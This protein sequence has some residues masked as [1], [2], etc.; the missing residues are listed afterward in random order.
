MLP[1][2]SVNKGCRS[3]Q[4]ITSQPPWRW[5]LRGLEIEIRCLPSSHQPQQ[6]TPRRFRMGKHRI[7]APKNWG[8]YQRSDFS[9]SGLL[10]FPTHRKAVNSLRCLFF[11]FQLKKIFFCLFRDA[12]VA[13]GGSQARGRTWAEAASLHHSSQQCW[14]LN[15]LSSPGIQPASSWIL[16][17]FVNHGATTR[18]LERSAFL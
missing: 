16:V 9:E 2:I 3:Y 12:P 10:H 14:I 18:M 17:G 7:L 1:A 5:T 13:Y 15:P 11:F 6:P 8:A 4:A